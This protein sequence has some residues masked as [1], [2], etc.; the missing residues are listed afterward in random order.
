MGAK[1]VALARS[2]TGWLLVFVASALLAGCGG[3]SG[4]H[5]QTPTFDPSSPSSTSGSSSPTSPSSSTPAPSTGTVK[6]IPTPRVVPAA[7][8]AVNA[9][10]AMVSSTVAAD[11]DPAHADLNTI[12][13]Y[14]SGKALK[15]IDGEYSAMAKAGQAYRGTP[16]DPRV[17]V[18]SVLSPTFVFLT[19]CPLAST[20]DPYTEYYVATGK[21]V[22]VAKRAPPPPYLLTLPMQEVG[23]QWKLTDILQNAGKTCTA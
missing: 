19:S 13:Q 11:R 8:G 12:N 9:Y 17:K 10:I 5:T 23:G 14:L 2:G 4:V 18:S 21:P 6:P 22:P 20:S 1:H 16:A 3:N 7:Q 15:L